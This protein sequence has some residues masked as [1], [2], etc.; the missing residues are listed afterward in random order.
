MPIYYSHLTKSF[1]DSEFEYTSYPEDIVEISKEQ[2]IQLLSAINH[3]NKDIHI[4]NGNILLIDKKSKITWETIRKKRDKL[5]QL[6]DWTQGR[7]V[8]ES[9]SSLWIT[10]RQS[11]RDITKTYNDPNSVIWPDPPLTV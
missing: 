10:Y 4:E 6:S 3:Q 9:V 8:P 1:Y 2:H 7:D 11:L 5:L